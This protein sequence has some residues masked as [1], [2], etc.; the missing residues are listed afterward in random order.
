MLR[1]YQ[2]MISNQAVTIL[3]E[4]GLVYLAM[5]PRTGK[6]LTAFATAQ[7]YGAQTILFVTKK[8]AK[9]DIMSQLQVDFMT[10]G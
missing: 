1:D 4:H 10:M 5:E 3:Q 9:A 2:D 7:R 8:K 6:T